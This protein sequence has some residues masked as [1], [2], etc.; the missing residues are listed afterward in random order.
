MGLTHARLALTFGP[1][2]QVEAWDGE[3]GLRAVPA[4]PDPALPP[5]RS[6]LTVDGP[7]V[8]LSALK[9]AE[10]GN[11]LVARL[12]NPTG[13]SVETRLQWNEL[14]RNVTEV[15]LDEEPVEP[16]DPPSLQ[17]DTNETILT[18]PAHHLRSFRI[19]VVGE[20]AAPN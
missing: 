1:H 15:R 3:L 10:D 4:G 11:G 5:G 9:P 12:L 16:T 8:V 17:T 2:P 19:G 6:L 20:G 18:I 7:G 14:G 13:T